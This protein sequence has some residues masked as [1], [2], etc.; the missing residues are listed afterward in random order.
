MYHV[1]D[2]VNAM[3][4]RFNPLGNVGV[5]IS[6]AINPLQFTGSFRPAF[7]R[8]GYKSASFRNVGSAGL[9]FQCINQLRGEAG[10]SYLELGHSLPLAIKKNKVMPFAATRMQL[11]IVI[12]SEVS[13]KEKDH[14][15]MRSFICG[16]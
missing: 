10:I 13:Q 14:H 16:I 12:L 9:S 2:T 8:R 3:L 4:F 6:A 7:Q 5:S 1:L 11:E 15:R